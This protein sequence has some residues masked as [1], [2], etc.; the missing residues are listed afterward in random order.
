M[1][2]IVTGKKNPLNSHPPN[3]S[4]YRYEKEI[5]RKTSLDWIITTT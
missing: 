5:P 2:S 1:H 4:L 3:S